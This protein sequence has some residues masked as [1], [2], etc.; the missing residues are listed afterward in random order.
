[1]DFNL[2]LHFFFKNVI[3]LIVLNK[4][5]LFAFFS[6]FSYTYRCVVLKHQVHKEWTW[7]LFGL[8][9][10]FYVFRCISL[11]FFDCIGAVDACE[12][13]DEELSSKIRSN[14]QNYQSKTPLHAESLLVE[15]LSTPVIS[16][17]GSWTYLLSWWMICWL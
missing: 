9:L 5:S 7:T 16:S 13:S 15:E 12:L 2:C 11:Q 3:F 8:P 17:R 10:C 4:N 6:L 1:M 14:K